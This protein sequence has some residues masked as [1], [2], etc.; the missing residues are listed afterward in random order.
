[1]KPG[2]GIARYATAWVAGGVLVAC[3]AVALTGR[4]GDVSVRLAPV[5]QVRLEDA[6]RVGGCRLTRRAPAPSTGP[7]AAAGAY[8]TSLPPRAV[9][10]ALRA[11]VVVIGYRGDLAPEDVEQMHT[12]Q[13]AIPTATIVMRRPLG[14]PDQVTVSAYRRAM[15][16]ARFDDGA[17]DAVRLFHGRYVGRGAVDP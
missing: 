3:G 9:G 14:S 6:A 16:C 13:R 17:R 15:A 2:S 12:L 10:G 8:Q 4:S 7:R 5:E 11:G 1:M